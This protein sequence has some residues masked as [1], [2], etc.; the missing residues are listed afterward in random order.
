MVE[1]LHSQC[2]GSGLIPSWRTKIPCATWHGQNN[3]NKGKLVAMANDIRVGRTEPVTH[4]ILAALFHLGIQ[5]LIVHSPL[6][7]S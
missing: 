6:F 5:D 7:K 2:R 3:N 1:T 4:D